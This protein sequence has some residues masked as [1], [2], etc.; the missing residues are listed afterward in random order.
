[1]PE[2]PDPAAALLAARLSGRALPA[3]PAPVPTTLAGAYDIQQ[4]LTIALGTPVLGWKVGRIPAPLIETLGAERVAGPV[5][6]IAELGGAAGAA[7]VFEGGAGAIEA[8]V[9]LRLRAV[10]DTEVSGSDDGAA[11]IGDIRAGFEVASSPA[12]DVHAHAPFGIVADI[13]INNGLLL[14]PSLDVAE[15]MTLAVETRIEGGTVGTGRAID[16]LDGP[17]GSLNFLLGLHRRGVIALAPGQWISAGA[18]T[19]VHPIVIGQR[20]EASFGAAATIACTAVPETGF[21]S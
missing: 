3:F 21:Q 19:G 14:G 1:M 13:G 9:M 12:P 16:V 5:L 11:W 20:A 10:P 15:F 8:E 18:I 2:V 17:W 6:R 4:R 7:M